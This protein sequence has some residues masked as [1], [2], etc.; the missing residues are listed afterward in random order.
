MLRLSSRSLKGIFSIEILTI[1]NELDVAEREAGVL[2]EHAIGS[3][4]VGSVTD[5]S[6]VEVEWLEL[7][8]RLHTSATRPVW[9]D[10]RIGADGG[11]AG[12][13]GGS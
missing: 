13:A 10:Y 4:G 6:H 8:S 12:S 5:M 3:I 9:S 2:V 1:L 7:G 11:V